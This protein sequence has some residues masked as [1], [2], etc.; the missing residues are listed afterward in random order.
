MSM[1]IADPLS[2]DGSNASSGYGNTVSG[3][4]PVEAT[5]GPTAQV[6]RSR[7]VEELKLR[8]S[9]WKDQLPILQRSA[10]SFQAVLAHTYWHPIITIDEVVPSSGTFPSSGSF[11]YG[12]VGYQT[13]SLRM[14]IFARKI[15]MNSMELRVLSK[16]RSLVP[17]FL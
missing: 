5:K 13:S 16:S 15:R 17:S 10:Q 7:T 4:G 11:A 8:T 3:D 9:R 1:V 14:P 6:S 2:L 12:T